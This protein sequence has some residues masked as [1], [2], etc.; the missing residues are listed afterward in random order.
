MRI[1]LLLNKLCLV[2]TRSIAKKACDNNLV[3]INDKT[4]KASATITE[5][6]TV[7]FDLSGYRNILRITQ[8]PKGNVSKKTA[9]EFYEV[10]SHEKLEIPEN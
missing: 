3:A 7:R 6:D 8:I 1:D 5:G 10:I 4:A 2:K 9:P